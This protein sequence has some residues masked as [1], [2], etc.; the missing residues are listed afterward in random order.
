MKKLPAASGNGYNFFFVKRILFMG[1][2]E[3]A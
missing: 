1:L 3:T 2:M